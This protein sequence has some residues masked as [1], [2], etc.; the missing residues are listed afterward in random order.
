LS[1]PRTSR[2]I[3]IYNHTPA[4]EPNPYKRRVSTAYNL[5]NKNAFTQPKVTAKYKKMKTVIVAV[6]LVTLS[7]VASAQK[8]SARPVNGEAADWRTP[9]E[10]SE[11]RST[12]RYG[13]TMAY[14]WRVAAAAPGQVKVEIFGKTGEGR[15]LVEVVVSRDGVFDPEA[16]HRADR[17]ILLIQNAI[18]AGEMDGKDASLALLRD[19]VITKT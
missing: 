17:P 5:W 7:V 6:L 10:R 9:A 4:A 3:G 13:E 12:P 15:D 11:Y 19:M 2:V 16:L 14:V 8:S 18:H 1:I